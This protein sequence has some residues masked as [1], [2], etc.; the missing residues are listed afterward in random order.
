MMF[1]TYCLQLPPFYENTNPTLLAPPLPCTLTHSAHNDLFSLIRSYL[2]Y[3]GL[4]YPHMDL[5]KEQN[6]MVMVSKF[7]HR[8]TEAIG[9]SCVFQDEEIKIQEPI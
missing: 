7:V 9:L 6:Q 2:K 4:V 5:G 3:S 8:F 1:P